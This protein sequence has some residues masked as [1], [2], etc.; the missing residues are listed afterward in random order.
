MAVLTTNPLDFQSMLHKVCDR[1]F[2]AVVTFQG[3][4]RGEE[5]GEPIL[6]I[7][8]EAYESMARQ[9]L[10]EIAKRAESQ[11]SVHVGVAHRIGRVAVGEISLL[12]EV[13]GA[14]RAEAFEAC[15]FVIDE[16]KREAPIWKV[17]FQKTA[18]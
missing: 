8:Y 7:T 15:Q 2:G 5:K 11:W 14:H 17:A 12:V 1:T 18:A 3:T 13:A 4:I 16:I 6:A 10:E 9:S